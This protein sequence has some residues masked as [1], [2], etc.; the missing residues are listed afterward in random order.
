MTGNTH[1]MFA[2]DSVATFLIRNALCGGD[3]HLLRQMLS[4]K[5]GTKTFRTIVLSCE[6]VSKV[7]ADGRVAAFH[8]NV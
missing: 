5:H 3:R 8:P 4:L 6:S 7:Y 2:D 1:W